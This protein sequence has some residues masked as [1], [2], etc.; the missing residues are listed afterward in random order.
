[1]FI[2]LYYLAQHFGQSDYM[3][4]IIIIIC[5]PGKSA[6]LFSSS[7]NKILSVGGKTVIFCV[8]LSCFSWVEKCTKTSFDSLLF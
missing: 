6:A 1:M 3:I 5:I 2:S 4:M 7:S 8:Y